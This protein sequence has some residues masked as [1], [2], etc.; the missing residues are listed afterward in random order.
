[1]AQAKTPASPRVDSHTM[2]VR[3]LT[4]EVRSESEPGKSYV[5]TLPYCPCPDFHWRHARGDADP[6]C[7]HLKAALATVA[8]WQAP[9]T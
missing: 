6:F 3:P 2:M 1:M 7:K 4:V 9:A 8:G 5:V